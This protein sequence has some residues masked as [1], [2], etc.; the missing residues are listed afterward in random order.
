MYRHGSINI[1][2]LTE[3][4]GQVVTH[5]TDLAPELQIYAIVIAHAFLAT[6]ER[7]VPPREIELAI[8]RKQKFEANPKQHTF[9]PK[10]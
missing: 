8:K 6:K 10:G 9:R 3:F 5:T 7:S 4:T 1:N 2:A